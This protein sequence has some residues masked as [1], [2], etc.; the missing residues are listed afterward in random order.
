MLAF[1]LSRSKGL[2]FDPRSVSLADVANL[3]QV[4]ATRPRRDE[5]E[6]PIF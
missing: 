4:Q 1:Q 5:T 3:G 2:D 6:S